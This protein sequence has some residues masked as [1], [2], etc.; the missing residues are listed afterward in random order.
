M[1]VKAAQDISATGADI[2]GQNVDLSA[3]RTLTLKAAQSQDSVN[4][5]S[6]GSQ[7]G[8]GVGFGLGGT[9][10]GFTIE[11]SASGQK[12]QEA[13]NSQR[14]QWLIVSRPISRKVSRLAS[15][16]ILGFT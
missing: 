7:F 9:Q 10:N 12:G 6:S 2:R 3:G 16:L 14:N 5:S 13:G 11:L 4:G 8:A 1:Q 15:H